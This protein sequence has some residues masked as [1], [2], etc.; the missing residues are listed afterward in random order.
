MV[1]AAPLQGVVDLAGAVGGDDHDRRLRRLDGAE[2]RNG[3][4]EIRQHLKQIGLEWLV[5]AVELVDQQDGC[6]FGVWLQ[7]LEKWPADQEALVED[8]ARELASVM[9]ALR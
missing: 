1:E 6:A 5:R 4:L 8:I 7:R 9:H 2:F 3:D